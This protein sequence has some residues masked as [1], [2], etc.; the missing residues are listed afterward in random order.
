MID[1]QTVF[2]PWCLT[3]Y[4]FFCGGLT[5]ALGLQCPVCPILPHY[6]GGFEWAPASWHLQR[7]SFWL[8]LQ[9][10][11]SVISLTSN[12]LWC[13]I[14]H[15]M[16]HWVEFVGEQFW[17]DSKRHAKY[18][19]WSEYTY[20]CG[21]VVSANETLDQRGCMGDKNLS[22]CVWFCSPTAHWWHSLWIGSSAKKYKWQVK[23]W[24]ITSFFEVIWSEYIA[25]VYPRYRFV[26]LATVKYRLY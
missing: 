7:I 13:S 3:V 6:D 23:T 1:Y 4:W 10:A 11:V 17:R 22:N 14:K 26:K 9:H 20:I 16:R 21:W 2:W 15:I 19:P 5:N 8:T 24:C 12:P 18:L 25:T